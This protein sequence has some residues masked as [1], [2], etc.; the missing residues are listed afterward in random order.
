VRRADAG[1]FEGMESSQKD[2]RKSLHVEEVPLPEFGPDEAYVA[3][4]ASSTN[5]NAVWPAFS[6]ASMGVLAKS[7]DT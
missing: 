4:L 2:P 5:F 7:S 6:E 1:M 3:V